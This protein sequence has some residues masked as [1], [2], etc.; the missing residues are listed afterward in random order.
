MVLVSRLGPALQRLN[1]NLPV[2]AIEG[3]VEE[4][5]REGII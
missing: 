5:C 2:E 4:I 3:L 1:P